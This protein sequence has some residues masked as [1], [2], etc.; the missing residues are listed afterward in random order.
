[1]LSNSG[2]GRGTGGGPVF[3]SIPPEKRWL[4]GALVVLALLVSAVGSY[5]NLYDAFWW[6]DK[7]LHAYAMFA[8]TLVAG[9]FAYGVVLTGGREHRFLLVAVIGG[10]GLAMGVVWE[11]WEWL[12]DQMVRPNAI[13]GKTDTITDLIVDFLGGVAAGYVTLR[14]SKK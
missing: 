9:L 3:F 4:A 14:W 7:I 12:Y 8:Y 11:V 10:L 1:V 6:F 2:G 5:F 13:L